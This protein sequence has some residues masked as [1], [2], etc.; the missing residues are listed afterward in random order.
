MVLIATQDQRLAKMKELRRAKHDVCIT[1]YE[2]VSACKDALRTV[3]WQVLVMDEAHRIKNRKSVTRKNLMDLSVKRKVLLT[4]TPL[5]MNL[6]ELW[7]LLNYLVPD[8]FDSLPQF[9][10]WFSA[11]PDFDNSVTLERVREAIKPFFLRRLKADVE[12]SIPPKKE[13]HIT[14]HL[15][16]LQKQIYRKI[17]QKQ[18]PN[19]RECLNQ[20]MELRKICNHPYLYPTV[21]DL[22][23]SEEKLVS[24]AGKLKMLDKLLPKL[25]ANNSKVLIFSQMTRM[26]TILED[27]CDL[28]EYTYLRLDGET[29]LDDR[30]T[31][32]DEFNNT[33]SEVFVFLLSTR[34]GGLGI[35][36]VAADTVII[37]D[38]DWNPQA[39]L[40]AMDRAHRIGQTKQVNVIRLITKNTVK[41]KMIE[42]QLLR[43][44]LGHMILQKGMGTE[45]CSKLYDTEV[46]QMIQFGADAILHGADKEVELADE[47][48]DAMLARGEKQAELLDGKIQETVREKE[49]QMANFEQRTDFFSFHMDSIVEHVEL[50]IPEGEITPDMVQSLF[51]AHDQPDDPNAPPE[52]KFRRRSPTPLVS[53]RKLRLSESTVSDSSVHNQL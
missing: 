28:R 51:E 32:M 53:S 49:E 52:A 30:R 25:K 9:E 1:S 35:N 6:G 18:L 12:K 37:Y 10:L 41:E 19:K 46:R 2:G 21:E 17:L 48:L 47:D 7:S 20:L 22:S 8:L 3:K 39:D 34:A 36:L 33:E 42:R 16:L 15:S 5:Q 31:R 43:L 26:L 40:Q 50:N 4:G 23:W 11:R 24:N 29:S 14:V 38:T 13:I 27:Y 44:K 45:L